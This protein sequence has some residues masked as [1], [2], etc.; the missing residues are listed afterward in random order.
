VLADAAAL[1]VVA[2]DPAHL[3][4]VVEQQLADGE[5]LPDLG[6][7]L[8]GRVDEQLVQHGA[9]RPVGDRRLVG[10]RS[11][12]DRERAEVERVGVDRRAA[13]GDEPIQQPPP[14]QRGDARRM[15]EVRRDR[16]AGKRRPVDH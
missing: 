5:A 15:D 8:G 13:G 12:G 7:C 11:A 16:V 10:A 1:P 2:A 6:A 4:V 9:P 14:L 3:A